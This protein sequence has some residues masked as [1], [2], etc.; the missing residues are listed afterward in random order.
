VPSILSAFATVFFTTSLTVAKEE[1]LPSHHS[2]SSGGAAEASYGTVVS[3]T[4][5]F[6][7]GVTSGIAGA[8]VASGP[9][10]VSGWVH[11]GDWLPV[12]VPWS[13]AVTVTGWGAA[14]A[15]T[16]SPAV[17][18]AAWAMTAYK[19]SLVS[20]FLNKSGDKFILVNH[21]ALLSLA[22]VASATAL[23][24]VVTGV[25]FLSLFL[26]KVASATASLSLA[27]VAPATALVSVVTGV[28]FLLLY[29][30]EVVSVSFL[31]SLAEV[32]SA[33][34]SVSV[35]IGVYFLSLSVAQVAAEVLAI[36]A[37]ASVVPAGV[38]FIFFLW[39]N[40]KQ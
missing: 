39:W 22:E 34:A 4:I 10:G 32:V 24:S 40:E 3:V 30:A 37:V 31:L 29:L 19:S 16:A 26:A 27:E 8:S 17:I 35:V 9:A 12:L 7:V 1:T 6:F 33:T 25:C 5:W 21:S 13:A 2:V 38:S 11:L 20:S 28:C 15:A 23:F 14:F 18:T 36:S